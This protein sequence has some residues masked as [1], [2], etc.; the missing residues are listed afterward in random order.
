MFQFRPATTVK[1]KQRQG[2]DGVDRNRFAASIFR[3]HQK[4]RSNE[5]ESESENLF[6]IAQTFINRERTR[7]PAA[8]GVLGI[9]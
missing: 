9:L 2:T 7:V 3:A 5:A 6:V 8:E 4:I 1:K